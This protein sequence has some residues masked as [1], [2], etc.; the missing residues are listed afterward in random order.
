MRRFEPEI[1]DNRPENR[2]TI[3]H[4]QEETHAKVAADFGMLS[5]WPYRGFQVGCQK[6][7][8]SNQSFGGTFEWEGFERANV[9]QPT[10]KPL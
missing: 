4:A 8:R 1:L 3:E 10:W 9:W 6:F 2:C 5:S 7:A